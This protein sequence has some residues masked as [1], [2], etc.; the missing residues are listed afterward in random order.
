MTP[1]ASAR[2]SAASADHAH[3]RRDEGRR[4]SASLDRSRFDAAVRPVVRLAAVALVVLGL[5]AVVYGTASLTGGWLGT[6]PWWERSRERT[7]WER[8]K[9]EVIA[10]V[11]DERFGPARLADG[12]P[13]PR[14]QP[15]EPELN[16][17]YVEP[18]EGHEWISGG[19]VA[20]GL[21]LAAFGAWPRRLR[22]R[23]P[24]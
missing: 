4:R 7:A 5:A 22:F 16:V 10:H 6:P 2:H 13:N 18:R 1:T 14:R 3:P 11:L 24:A 9:E 15:P 20:T 19:V 12:S 8:T 23:R 17:A 21:A